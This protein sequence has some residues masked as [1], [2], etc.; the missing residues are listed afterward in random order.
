MDKD[1]VAKALAKSWSRAT[2]TSWTAEQPAAGQCNVTALLVHALFGGEILKT[3]TPS[4]DH[5][6]NRIDGERLDFT[7]SQFEHTL[8]Y[9]D[10]PASIPETE[11]GATLAERGALRSAFLRHFGSLTPRLIEDAF[12]GLG[13]RARTDGRVIDIAVYG[14]SALML[15]SNFRASTADVDA[16]ASDENQA[17][18]EACADELGRTLGLPTGWLNDQV[19][20]YL[21]DQVD[22]FACEH[23]HF[24]SYPNEAEP[25]LRVYVPTPEYMCA[26]KLIALRIEPGTAAKDFED[27]QHLTALLR[28]DTPQKALALVSQFYAKGEV[29]GRVENGIRRLYDL[30]RER[31]DRRIAA[32]IYHGR[33]G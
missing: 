22:G 24:R 12:A 16:V 11:R 31:G 17:Y 18:L 3:Q 8:S 7:A 15:V 9:D 23:S 28:L 25:G 6:Y 29:A 13:Q 14:G 21:S 32:P 5:F 27:L 2:A 30:F 10:A 26:L 20:P 4:G 19:F 33:G 1:R